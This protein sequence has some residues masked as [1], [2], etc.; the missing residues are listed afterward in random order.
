M[1][2]DAG[3][4]TGDILQ[5]RETPIEPEEDAIS[6]RHRLSEI[7]ASLMLETLEDSSA[8]LSRR[9][10]RTTRWLPRRPF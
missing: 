10:L 4:D 7:G 1:R 2:M 8:T 6:L 3:L 9:F 5:A